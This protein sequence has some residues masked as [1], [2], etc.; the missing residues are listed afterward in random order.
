[1]SGSSRC[2]KR[3]AANAA[4]T[5]PAQ[6]FPRRKPG[7]SDA[8]VG[9]WTIGQRTAGLLGAALLLTLSALAVIVTANAFGAG[10][11]F[12]DFFANWSVAQLYRAG[13][14]ARVYDLAFLNTFRQSLDGAFDPSQPYLIL[15]Y[16]YPPTYLF[17][18]WPLRFLGFAPAYAA[19]VLAT[20]ALYALAMLPWIERKAW[21]AAAL[22]LLVAPASV[23]CAVFGQN[24]F[25]TAALITLGLRLAKPRP[26]LAGLLLG[27]LAFKPQLGILLPVALVSAGLWRTFAAAA[28]TAA[29]MIAASAA[30]LGAPLWHDWFGMATGFSHDLQ[31]HGQALYHL[32]P[33]F[34]ANALLAGAA[35]P[36]AQ[37]VQLA[38]TLAVAA[39]VWVA[40]R[41]GP[42]GAAIA[43]LQVGTLLA[44][45][46]GFV[47]DMPIVTLAIIGLACEPRRIGPEAII[48]T[49]ALLL[50]Y[51]MAAEVTR[52]P[53]S[54]VTLC[55]LLSIA[56]RRIMPRVRQ[57]TPP[58]FAAVG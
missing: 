27:L 38:G 25:L 1:M 30:L 50:P 21:P 13:Q 39:A 53:L 14:I 22:L 42:S 56:V 6:V 46:F 45:P 37:S 44:T 57:A 17:V 28:V 12:N 40:F 47:Y 3:P 2:R 51:L 58:G 16:T 10:A 26:L 23:D 36:V 32:M 15:P 20:F 29:L 35:W 8:S 54:A 48:A 52:L 49:A 11:P 31:F 34:M 9:Y 33:T 5:S 24:G 19:W 18:L 41:G 4:L 7:Q 55:L 43:A